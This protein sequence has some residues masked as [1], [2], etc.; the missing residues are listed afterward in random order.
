MKR[1]YYR[2]QMDDEMYKIVRDR[3][4]CAH[5]E[6]LE[7]HRNPIQLCMACGPLDFVAMNILGPLL[8]TSNRNQF[9][10]VMTDRY[11]K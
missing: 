11:W 3:R 6:L 8:K 7:K 2:R 9:E 5:S 4:E 1:V 10:L